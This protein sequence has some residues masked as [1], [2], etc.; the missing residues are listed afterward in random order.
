MGLRRA[1]QAT[2][3][4]GR[5]FRVGEPRDGELA[6]MPIDDRAADKTGWIGQE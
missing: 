6:A 4:E 2:A 5:S 1:S 3:R